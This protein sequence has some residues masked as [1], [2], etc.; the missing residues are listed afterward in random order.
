[1]LT[2]NYFEIFSLPLK[3]EID[4]KSLKAHYFKLQQEFH[5]DN[6]QASHEKSAAIKIA[7]KINI[8]YETLSSK[9]ERARYLL[10]IM[11]LTQSEKEMVLTSEFLINQM[12]LREKLNT[13]KNNSNELRNFLNTVHEKIAEIFLQF[14]SLFNQL[15]ESQTILN[16]KIGELLFLNKLKTEAEQHLWQS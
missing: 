15:P 9:L 3:Y 6:Y 14:D 12:E 10:N 7:S 5:P 13:I 2:L 4:L 11:G 8:A 16:Q 1:M